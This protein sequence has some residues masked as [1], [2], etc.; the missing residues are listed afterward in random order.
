MERGRHGERGRD[1]ESGWDG[2]WDEESGREGG[3]GKGW[4]VKGKERVGGRKS[5]E[6]DEE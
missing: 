6:R 5:R 3:Q 4:R 1:G 2:G